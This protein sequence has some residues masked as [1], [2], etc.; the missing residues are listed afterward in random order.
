MQNSFSLNTTWAVEI[1]PT[2]IRDTGFGV[3]GSMIRLG[4]VISQFIFIVIVNINTTATIWIYIV[5]VILIT[6]CLC[7][8]PR[9]E[10]EE[11]DSELE[12][13]DFE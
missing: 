5:S 2:K 1:L 10:I 11:L 12:L 4:A 8:L 13:S 9:N 7:F 3:F 6:I